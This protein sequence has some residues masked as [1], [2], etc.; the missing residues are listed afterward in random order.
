MNSPNS[1]Y[2][3]IPSLSRY[4]FYDVFFA[5]DVQGAD[6]ALTDGVP[7]NWIIPLPYEIDPDESIVIKAMELY[8][9]WDAVQ[10]N[11]AEGVTYNA[12]MIRVANFYF[13]P[14]ETLEG[15][16][17]YEDEMKEN[18]GFLDLYNAQQDS[19]ANDGQFITDMMLEYESPLSFPLNVAQKTFAVYLGT[20]PLWGV[21][22]FF[23]ERFYYRVGRSQLDA[24][25]RVI[26]L[27]RQEL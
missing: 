13:K 25:E 22:P 21:A 8:I 4:D 3:K 5:D 17:S 2:K 27:L 9:A 23:Y 6:T 26:L 7:Q 10:D 11:W 12:E 14:D 1:V 19:G 16:A 24:L 18:L 15:L 20:A